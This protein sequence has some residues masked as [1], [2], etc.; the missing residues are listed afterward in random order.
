MGMAHQDGLLWPWDLSSS[1]LPA[2]C[3]CLTQPES[4]HCWV[5]VLTQRTPTT[6]HRLQQSHRQGPGGGGHVPRGTCHLGTS[7]AQ[8]SGPRTK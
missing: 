3:S 7:Q 6:N 1:S 4:L 5:P 8:L 2:G